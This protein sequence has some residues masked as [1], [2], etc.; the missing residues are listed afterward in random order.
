VRLLFRAALL[1]FLVL[2]GA[3]AYRVI[4]RKYYVWGMGYLQWVAQAEQTKTGPTHLFFLYTDHFEPGEH[5]DLVERWLKEYPVLAGHHRDSGGRPVQHTW[6]YPAEQPI[7]RNMI[8]LKAMAEGG[9]GEIELHLHH[10]HDTPESARRRFEQGVAYFQQFGYLKG[11]DGRSHFAFIHGN[12]SL[13]NSLGEALC[14][15]SREL[16]MLKDLGCF[17]DF[18]FPSLWQSSQP[19]WVNSIYDVTDDDRPKS[20][21]RG[22]RVYM[23]WHPQGDLLLV[24]GPLVIVPTVNPAKL[25]F[26]VEDGDVHPAVPLTPQRVDAWVHANVHVMGRP[27]WVFLK[28]H[29][30][31]ASSVADLEE[32]LGPHFDNALSYLERQYNDGAHYILHYVTA[33]EAY[34]LIRA[35]A[36]NK[37]GEPRQY[38]NYVIPPYQAN[39]VSPRAG[40]SN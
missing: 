4:S 36:D 12:W 33:R 27:D 31:A 11:V 39:T 40:A 25:F 16:R 19:S 9:Y 15:N 29:G 28:V 26:L 17:A 13:D 38:L 7:D 30:H 14:G 1:C 34:N 5:F 21:D 24:Q 23:G 2:M 3:L 6:F 22:I 20:Y 18:T 32:T 37:T 10:F 8:A 35:A